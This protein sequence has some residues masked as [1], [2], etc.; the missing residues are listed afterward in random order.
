MLRVPVR[1]IA[2]DYLRRVLMWH[3]NS[4]LGQSVSERVRVISFKRLLRHANVIDISHLV[5]LMR[6]CVDFL[7]FGLECRW[8]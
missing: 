4:G 8:L 3:H 1:A 6:E 5:L 7:H 2:E